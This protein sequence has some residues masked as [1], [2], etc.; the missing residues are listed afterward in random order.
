VYIAAV[1]PRSADRIYVRSYPP[2]PAVD[3]PT[4]IPA[5]LLVS[6]A[7]GRQGTFREVARTTNPM[8]GATLSPD[9]AKLAFGS[10][11]RDI[12]TEQPDDGVYVGPA[13]F[14]PFTKVSAIKN[15]CLRWT[16]TGLY[17]CATQPPDNFTVGVSTD[18]GRTFR[19]LY[20][21][22]ETCPLICPTTTPV[23][24]S[25][26]K[27]WYDPLDPI[28][29]LKTRLNAQDAVCSNSGG[30]GGSPG[31]GG[32]AGSGATPGGCAPAPPVAEH[33]S[34]S[35]GGARLAAPVAGLFVI[36]FAALGLRRRTR[37]GSRDDRKP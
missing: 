7:G 9:G 19:P 28:F 12:T 21:R 2:N 13:P 22:E 35:L 1:D 34:C 4:P 29:S 17:A 5:V 31:T 3:D 36:A 26:P 25:C 20:K 32:T 14:G 24:A 6:E 15:R 10:S 11:S 30:T 23:G 16:A 8:L 37:A 33:A 27:P 18:E